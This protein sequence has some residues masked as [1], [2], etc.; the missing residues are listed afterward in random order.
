MGNHFNA[1]SLSFYAVAI[2]SVLLLFNVVT[3]YGENNLTAPKTIGGSYR[4][5]FTNSLPGCL[6]I[7]PL[8]LQLDQSGTY[9]NAAVLK[10]VAKDAQSSMSAEEKLTLTG[11]FKNQQLFLT[12]KV[13]RSVLCNQPQA[14]GESAIAL[15]SRIEGENLAG[16][17]ALNGEPLK[18]PFTAQKEALPTSAPSSSH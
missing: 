7:A 11:L 6:Q 13:P 2:G 17:I 3:A 18:T 9:V 5:S 4:L 12:G 14:S 16:S 1:K 10:P 8:V 15:T